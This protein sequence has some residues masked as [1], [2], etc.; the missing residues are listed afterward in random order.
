MAMNEDFW[1]QR[2]T[3]GRV[4][5][6][7]REDFRCQVASR[8]PAG[9]MPSP[10]ADFAQG[11]VSRS[12]VRESGELAPVAGA[13]EQKVR[14][15]VAGIYD[16]RRFKGGNLIS[17]AAFDKPEVWQDYDSNQFYAWCAKNRY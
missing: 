4:T 3:P 9:G 8:A 11:I 13:A 1:A 17:K 15:D 16:G 10:S 12:A 7:D 14:I 5:M 6:E 2:T